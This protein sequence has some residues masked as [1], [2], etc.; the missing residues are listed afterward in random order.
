MSEGVLARS[1]GPQRGL[2]DDPPKSGERPE[3]GRL[4]ASASRSEIAAAHKL[5]LE[6]SKR[7]AGNFYYAFL[8]LPPK[9]RHGIQALYA[10]CRAG[11]D[12]ADEPNPADRKHALIARLRRRVDLVFNGRYCDPQT[13]AL[14]D[15]VARFGF[16]RQPFDDLILGVESDIAGAP[17]RTME[18]LLLYCYRVASTV[19]LIC[20]K[21]FGADSVQARRYAEELGYG[22]QLTNILRDVRE[23]YASDRVYLPEDAMKAHGLSKDGL[24]KPRS[25]GRLR[26]LLIELVGAARE[27]FE[28]AAELEPREFHRELKTAR[29]MGNI[30]RS[31]LVRIAENPLVETRVELSR[32]EKLAIIRALV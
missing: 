9:R 25:A 5:C 7:A 21:I 1:F 17:I 27:H 8:L 4:L 30:Y 22:M 11:D 23:D 26:N 31:I 10:F 20:L 6:I 15:A 19:G 3:E 12:A 18:E 28:R 2:Q 16:E 29:A 24:L 14:A 32:L 13:L